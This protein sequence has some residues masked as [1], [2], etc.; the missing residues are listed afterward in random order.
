MCGCQL[1]SSL[2]GLAR[3]AN[4]TRNVGYFY[5]SV[6]VINASSGR[7]GGG[8]PF[9]AGLEKKKKLLGV[10]KKKDLIR[11]GV[12]VFFCLCPPAYQIRCHLALGQG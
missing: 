3:S 6:I 5:L 9:T 8:A 12:D 2:P 4:V 11:K 7:R 1:N 10:G